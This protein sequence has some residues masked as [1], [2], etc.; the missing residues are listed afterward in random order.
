MS[1]LE[2]LNG[3]VIGLIVR[4]GGEKARRITGSGRVKGAIKL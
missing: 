1:N 4:S 3:K 2:T